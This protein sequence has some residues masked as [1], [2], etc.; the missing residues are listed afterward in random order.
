MKLP[1]VSGHLQRRFTLETNP[2][3]RARDRVWA[4]DITYIPTR[5]GWLYLAVILD[6]ASRRVVGWALRTQL[7][8]T[9]ALTAL[10]MALAHRQARWIAPFG[11][12]R[13]VHERYQ[14]LLASA[15]LHS[16]HESHRQLLRQCGRREFSSP[17]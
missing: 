12:R 3:L 16:Q 6:L 9:L 10:R 4:A 2:A 8:Q 5:E 13:A 11:S 17:P 14:Q 15:G 7:D 1:R